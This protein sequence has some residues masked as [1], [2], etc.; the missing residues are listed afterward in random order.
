VLWFENVT[1]RNRED[2][3]NFF[4]ETFGIHLQLLV[5]IYQTAVIIIFPMVLQPLLSQSLL[6]IDGLQSRSVIP[7][8]VGLL[9]TSDQ[10][11]PET[12]T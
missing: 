4:L 9:W 7:Q 2:G 3:H 8:S 5:V 1:A 6:F 10:P 11:Y 12:S